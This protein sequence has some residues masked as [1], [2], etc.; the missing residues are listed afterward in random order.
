M[1][2]FNVPPT[3]NIQSLFTDN[4]SAVLHTTVSVVTTGTDCSWTKIA[5]YNIADACNNTT[6]VNITFT[7]GDSSGPAPTILAGSLNRTV[8]Y[9]DQAGLAAAQALLPSFA[10]CSTGSPITVVKQPGTFV[11]GNCATAGTIVNLFIATDACGN[12]SSFTQGIIITDNTGPVISGI[13]NQTLSIGGGCSGLLPDYITSTGISATDC[14]PP[15]NLL[16]PTPLIVYNNNLSGNL[17]IWQSPAPG[18]SIT[19]SSQVTI[20]AMDACGNLTTQTFTVTVVAGALPQFTTCPQNMSVSTAAPNGLSGCRAN[21]ALPLPVY[22][23]NCTTTLQ[24][25]ISGATPPATI[26]GSFPSSYIMNEGISTLTYR[27][28]D[29]NGNSTTCSFTVTVTNTLNATIS[30]TT[31]A[32]QNVS[33]STPVTFTGINGTPIYTFTYDVS[34]NAG[35]FGAPQSVSSA[36]GQSSAV[37][38]QSNAVTGIYTY[39]LL[40]V[41]DA[42]G[43]I[44][45]LASPIT[46]V[47]TVIPTGTGTPDLTSSQFFSST[48]IPAGGFIDL[49]VI[50][51]NVGSAP[52]SGPIVINFTNYNP[53]TGLTLTQVLGNTTMVIGIDTYITSPGWTINPGAGTI[54]S[55]NVI[56]PGGSNIIGLRITRGTG[57]NAGA[58]GA[59]T[60]TITIPAGTGGGESPSANNTISNSILK[61]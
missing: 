45:S 54:T 40:S 19:G 8:E 48:Q 53:L 50:V 7:G 16:P 52:T 57:A 41:M 27:L 47:I 49:A 61:N 59:V 1:S 44:K 3:A 60:F 35:P 55:N 23:S 43:C 2:Q 28:T 29:A 18:T 13:Q 10:D 15:N 4:C 25:T 6:T 17:R 31:N 14:N 37:I 30:G 46:A 12:T 24:W 20:S 36:T 22:I 9:C 11:P 38:Q 26:N 33:T 42:N 51:R 32:V 58:N 34:V 56:A 39:R 21:V 5:T